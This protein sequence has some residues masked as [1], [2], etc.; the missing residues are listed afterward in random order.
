[1]SSKMV[2]MRNVSLKF[3]VIAA[4]VLIVSVTSALYVG[5]V[6][7]LKAQLEATI[8][9]NM[10]AT[11]LDDLQGRLDENRY[12]ESALFVGWD[13]YVGE[14]VHTL[15]PEITSLEAGSHHSVMLMDKVYQVEVSD[16][17]G[18]AVYLTYDITEWE[19]Q[20]HSVLIMLVYG[21]V[22]VLCVSLLMGWSA[23]R[24]ILSPVRRLAARLT[25]M[26][27]GERGAPLAEDYKGTEI[28]QI[29]AAF[30]K[31]MQRLDQFVE[32]ERTFTAA[33]SHELR[34]P[35]SVM[36]GAVDVLA[37]SPQ[38]AVSLRAIER[39]NRACREM[40]AFIEATLYLSR[41]GSTQI[42]QSTPADLFVIAERLLEDNAATLESKSIRVEK[43]FLGKPELLQPVSLIQIMLG[44]ILRN[45]IEH[46]EQG[47]ITIEIDKN[48]MSI[49][50][51]G[52]GIAAAHL[53]QV[54]E[55]TYSTKSTGAG[56]GLNLVKRICDRFHWQLEL[57]SAIGVGTTVL[58]IFKTS[59][60]INP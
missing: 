36:M 23:T 25:S 52:E 45:A 38:S 18:Q 5:G 2:L 6:L 20:E 57:N 48:R 49:V 4:L 32:R 58:I 59:D 26:Q 39:I 10:V 51:T 46:T 53:T 42:D 41:E 15:P 50:D 60:Q 12:D 54:F 21:L 19:S 34:T 56:L 33:A 47:S 40:L 17:R 44:N 8:F 37:E 28:G 30:D 9:G 16:W 1:M 31:Y 3:R 22:I 43:H 29:A 7:L 13:F 14:S 24:V 11:Q 35:L 27:P 55:R